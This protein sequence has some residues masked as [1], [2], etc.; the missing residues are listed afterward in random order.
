MTE[1][2]RC[3]P[4]ALRSMAAVCLNAGLFKQSKSLLLESLAMDPKDSQARFHLGCA[5]QALGEVNEAI[6]AF[7]ESLRRSPGQASAHFRLGVVYREL[8]RFEEASKCYK[9]ALRLDPKHDKARFDLALIDLL[10]GNTK[11]GFQ[12]YEYR[13][14][15]KI[16][17]LITRSAAPLWL[18]GKA[19]DKRT[20]LLHEEQGF[21][22]TLQFVRYLPCVAELGASVMLKV[23]PELRELMK[24][25][26][27]S[28]PVVSSWEEVPAHDF[29]CTLPSLPLACQPW[30]KEHIPNQ[31]PYLKADA[32]KVRRWQKRLGADK[33]L[34]VGIVWAGNPLLI[35]NA[36]RSIRLGDFRD[37]I[38]HVP[39]R[40]IRLQKDIT[41]EDRLELNSSGMMEEFEDAFEDFSETAALVENLDL[42]ISVDTCATH[43]A[44]SLGRPFWVLVPHVPD[45]R[46]GLGR[47]D[48]DWYPT[49]RIFRQE[50]AGDWPGLLSRVGAELSHLANQARDRK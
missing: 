7:Q 48:S 45:W 16:G 18:G 23:Q 19:I 47:E 34:R 20:L 36:R 28:I 50:Q 30:L 17:S 10:H 40:F 29:Q 38:D 5:C 37:I 27:P 46:W 1:E 35:I 42:V 39:C 33:R 31:V 21:G 15:E 14:D 8:G 26:F 13:W 49:A 22:D 25:S 24:T 44:G 11:R 2:D 4:E 9:R 6:E 41:P 32:R 12:G 3:C 43:L